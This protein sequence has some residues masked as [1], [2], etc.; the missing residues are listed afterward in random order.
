M[1]LWTGLCPCLLEQLF[2][3][4]KPGFQDNADGSRRR[5][6]RKKKSTGKAKREAK[7]K[8]AGKAKKKAE[9]AAKK[10]A[11]KEVDCTKNPADILKARANIAIL[12]TESASAIAM[13]VIMVAKAGQ[14]A[15][16]KYLFEM[17]GVYPATAEAAEAPEDSLAHTLLRRLGLPT[18]PVICVED[19]AATAFAN[20]TKAG[21]QKPERTAGKDSWSEVLQDGSCEGIVEREPRK[22]EKDT[23]E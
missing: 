13:G 21:A 20:T 8:A 15:S 1:Y 6:L 23:V 11:A 3:A 12:V 17:A 10:S 18:E 5:S 14:L 19:Q 7:E 4:A 2:L 9:G 22:S 16:A